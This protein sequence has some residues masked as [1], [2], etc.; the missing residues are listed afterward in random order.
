[1]RPP[2]PRISTLTAI[3]VL[4]GTALGGFVLETSAQE[5]PWLKSGT[6]RLDFAPTFWTWDSRYGEGP[7]GEDLEEEVGLD[8]TTSALGS[9]ALPDLLDLEAS[10]AEALGDPA[11]R[12]NLGASQAYIDQSRLILPFRLDIGITDWLTIGAMAPL[13][14]PRTEMLF[15]LDGDS[16]TATDGISPF[17]SDPGGV[18]SFLDAFRNVLLNAKASFPGDP[19][20]S[21][22]EAYFDALTAAYGHSTFF[23]AQ[24]SD[25]G[26]RLQER[27]DELRDALSALGVTGMPETVPLASGYLSEED[28]Q[29]FLEGPSMRSQPLED[30]TTLW[31]LGDVEVTA[32]IRLLR[33]GFEPDSSGA[34]PFLRFQL[35]VGGLVRLGTGSQADPGRFYDQDQGDGQMDLEGNVFGLVQ[36]GTRFGAWGQL[37]YGIQNEGDVFRR[38]SDP[39]GVLPSYKRL[40]PLKWTPGDYFEL[41]LNPRFFLTPDMSF[42]VR[43]HLWAKGEDSYA[44]GEIVVPEGQEPREFPDPSLLNLETEERLQEVGFSATFSSVDAHGRGEASMPLYIRATYFHPVGGSGGQTPKG[45]RLQVGLTLFKTLWGSSA[46][47]LPGVVTGG[48]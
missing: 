37:R 6:V 19:A 35:G 48:R 42:G 5:L 16:T 7:T 12:V 15:V 17:A 44:L 13:V 23:P 43:Y 27:L 24:G 46:E 30:W 47:E 45:G 40:A 31:S 28:F 22:A 20:V 26:A 3:L 8:L 14:R 41:D 25:P 2:N 33:R 36:L 9:Q 11:Y 18:I 29:E 10:L 21:D 32:D 39:S 38:I 1:M 34:L 4:V